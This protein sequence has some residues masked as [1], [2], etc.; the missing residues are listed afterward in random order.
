M[1]DINL[2]RKNPDLAKEKIKSRNFDAQ[3]VDRFLDLDT[4]VNN[5]LKRIEELRHERNVNSKKKPSDEDHAFLKHRKGTIKTLEMGL[6]EYTKE[7][8]KILLSL[9]NIPLDD[10]KIGQSDK[11]NEIVKTVGERTKFNF[12]PKDYLTLTQSLDLI[13]LNQAALVSGSRFSYLKGRLVQLQQ[14]VLNFAFKHLIKSGFKPL[15]PP[16]M[17]KDEVMRGLGY[18][19]GIE[20]QEKY[21]FE[22]DGL[23]LI[24]T[25]EHSLI[26]YHMN[27][28]LKVEALP[29]RYFAFTPAFRREAGSYG[30]DTRG[31]L[32]SHQFDKL[33]MVSFSEPS[34]SGEEQLHLFSVVE[35]LM[36]DLKLPYRVVKMCTGDL[37]LPSA[38]TFDIETWLP[39]QNKYRETHSCSNCT[40]YQARRLRIKFKDKN[41]QTQFVHTLNSTVFAMGRILIAIM[42]NYQTKEGTVKVPKILQKYCGFKEIK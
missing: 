3:A 13:D 2:I 40:D 4:K 5:F 7:R 34:K 1:L 26:P 30:Q 27:Q 17:I 33:E 29:L 12:S 28:T 20:E 32:R 6:A 21:H 19:E 11:D 39:G 10:V 38:R 23:Y 42:E 24:A 15:V 37:V 22:K 8:D 31:I 36:A 18:I 25:A 35:K 41:N 9:P 14:A 16:L